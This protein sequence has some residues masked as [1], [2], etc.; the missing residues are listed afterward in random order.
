MSNY[1][2]RLH[3]YVLLSISIVFEVLGTTMMKLSN[4][5]THPLFSIITLAAYVMTFTLLTFTLKRLP[6]GL[7]YGIWGG[8]GTILTAIIGIVVW[9]DPLNWATG[10][11]IA[12]IVGGIVLLN[13]GTQDI[14]DKLAQQGE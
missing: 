5:F 13:K 4:G 1:I 14:E 8:V 9:N 6:L 12:L 3:P 10:A 11:G 7:V 2:N